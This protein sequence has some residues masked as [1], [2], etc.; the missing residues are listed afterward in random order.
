MKKHHRVSLIPGDGI[1]PEISEATIKV[2]EATSVQIDY[3]LCLAGAAAEERFGNPL[4]EETLKSLCQT[5]VGL[6]GPLVVQPGSPP[7]VIG[8]PS[9]TY[10][11]PNGALRGEC[12]IFA[13]I[14]P[15]KRFSGVPGRFSDL[16][17]NLTIVREVSEGIY[18]GGERRIGPDRAEAV[19][20]ATEKAAGRIAR[21]AFK[22]AQNEH[23]KK[24]TL[25]H[26][27][28]V[29]PYTDGLY[30]EA[31]Y[32]VAREFPELSAEDRMIDAAAAQMVLDPTAYDL[33]IAPNQYGDIL[34]DL[35]A[36]VVGGLG[37]GPGGNYGEKIAFFE[38]CHGAA[39]DIAGRDI[40]NPVALILSGAMMLDYL[41]EKEAADRVRRGV[42]AYF[43]RGENFTPDLGGMGTTMGT[44]EAIA[45]FIGGST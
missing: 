37:V 23:R 43:K 19:V 31:F 24:V 20:V 41:D 28:N 25:V 38:A 18:V 29:L 27:A 13:N 32:R 26:K 6:K 14:R 10:G 4:P 9:R 39:P 2:L 12:G 35:A 17:I 36:A 30:L 1:G 42:E 45:H 3:E 15:A 8:H 16:P 7:V 11:S 44:S 33:I 5:G 40:A 22:L 34:S 21:F